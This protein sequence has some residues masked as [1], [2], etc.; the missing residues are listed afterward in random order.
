M[1]EAFVEHQPDHFAVD[2]AFVA[3]VFGVVA[4]L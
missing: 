2:N 1:A 4:D 3:V